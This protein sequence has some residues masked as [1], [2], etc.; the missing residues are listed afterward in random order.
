M[1]IPVYP[2]NPFM[3]IEDSNI[4]NEVIKVPANNPEF[5]PRGVPFFSRGLVLRRKDNQREL[6]EGS[7]YYYARPFRKFTNDFGRNAYGSI[8]LRNHVAEIEV[9]LVTYATVGIPFNLDDIKLATYVANLQ[10]ND[11]EADFS[12]LI[13][14]PSAFPPIPHQWPL[15]QTYDYLELMT[16]MES[17]ISVKAD[18]IRNADAMAR[19]DAHEK[20]DLQK[21][22]PA[23]AAMVGLSDTP[24]MRAATATDLKGGSHNLL[25]TVAMTKELLKLVN[26]G[27]VIIS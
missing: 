17:L 11:R 27:E 16:R 22:H 19:I 21:A 8:V 6:I 23:T 24:N 15:N 20:K 7:D 9:E 25:M 26:N 10:N 14:V 1:A 13:N 5:V 2:W 4:K 12:Q 3:T 18:A